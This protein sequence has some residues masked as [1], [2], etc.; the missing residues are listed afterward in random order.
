MSMRGRFLLSITALLFLAAMMTV[1]AS[2]QGGRA[3][4]LRSRA[5]EAADATRRASRAGRF[6]AARTANRT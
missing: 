2:G 5:A 6:R 4:A 1:P 3:A